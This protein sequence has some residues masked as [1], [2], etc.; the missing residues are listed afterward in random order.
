MGQHYI[1][2]FYL[3][4]F[5][6]GN[7]IWVHDKLVSRSFASQPKTVAN[8]NKIYPDDVEARLANAIEAPANSVIQKVRGREALTE[9]DRLALARY[10]VMLWKRVPEGRSRAAT[11]LPEVAASLRQEIHEGLSAVAREMP[12]LAAITEARK[13]E[14]DLVIDKYSRELPPNIWQT[15]LTADT[16]WDAVKSLLSMNWRFLWSDRLQFLTCDN[17]VFFFSHEG[18]GNLTSE[19][20]IP[21][22]SSVVLWA[23]RR[24]LPA[25]S[26]VAAPPAVVR[27]INRRMAY[28]STRFVYAQRAEAWILPFV[29]KGDYALN[30]L[31]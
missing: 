29:C 14:V 26:V 16:S 3:R 11:L 24:R 31:L 5:T 2:Q 4:G 20:T 17:P 15:S 7:T 10:V 1:P 22:S 25:A 8:E 13:A 21:L 27:E 18:I 9:D 19:L 6:E 23:N 30:R 12:D 28:N